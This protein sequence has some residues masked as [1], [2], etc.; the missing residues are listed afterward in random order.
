MAT[1]A[2]AF[3]FVPSLVLVSVNAYTVTTYEPGGVPLFPD[4]TVV[5]EL[6]PQPTTAAPTRSNTAA[7]A[8]TWRQTRL[9]VCRPRAQNS[10]RRNAAI[11][12]SSQ[13]GSRERNRR[14]VAAA[15]VAT[16]TVALAVALEVKSMI[17][18]LSVF[19]VVIE[20]AAFG[21][22]VEQER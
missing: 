21:A 8:H 2:S 1:L 9:R 16:V 4:D 18:G 17:F 14:S 22:V 11:R 7:I 19:P 3:A 13:G 10:N 15:V 12:V 5:A 6:P 20:Q